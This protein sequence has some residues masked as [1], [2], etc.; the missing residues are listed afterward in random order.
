[1]YTIP[2]L[3]SFKLL[4]PKYP[5]ERPLRIVRQCFVLVLIKSLVTSSLRG[6]PHLDVSSFNFDVR[7]SILFFIARSLWCISCIFCCHVSIV[8]V[9]T[10]I[11][12][13]SSVYNISFG[14]YLLHAVQRDCSP[15]SLKGS[16]NS[17]FVCRTVGIES[18]DLSTYPISAVRKLIKAA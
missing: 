5:W 6:V 15:L 14:L 8:D 3:S 16:S 17:Q 11:S 7:Q 1:M 9:A 10:G 18:S 12:D 4:L 13:G 2:L